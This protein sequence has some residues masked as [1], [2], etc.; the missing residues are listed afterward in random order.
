[1]EDANRWL[2][3]AQGREYAGF[4]Y[5]GLVFFFELLAFLFHTRTSFARKAEFLSICSL[6][7][8]LSADIEH[9]RYQHRGEA[10]LRT[11]ADAQRKRAEEAI[12]NHAEA[13]KSAEAKIRDLTN[14]LND[15]ARQLVDAQLRVKNV[16]D[17]LAIVRSPRALSKTQQVALR[18]ALRPYAGEKLMIRVLHGDA[19]AIELAEQI[20]AALDGAGWTLSPWLAADPLADTVSGIMVDVVEGAGSKSTEAANQLI[21]ALRAA[22]LATMGPVPLRLGNPSSF[23]KLIVGRKPTTELH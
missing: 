18:E 23:I 4:V 21:K 2:H 20:I 12:A 14:A 8:L 17:R 16:S 3:L 7:M 6:A 1:V 10:A 19:E 13:I 11:E 5:L 9:S 15:A 22:N